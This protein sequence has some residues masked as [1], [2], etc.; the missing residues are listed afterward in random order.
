M[1]LIELW[2]QYNKVF[3]INK[4]NI[5]DTEGNIIERNQYI[6]I[7]TE[8]IDRD[9]KIEAAAAVSSVE[10]TTMNNNFKDEISV[11]NIGV[12]NLSS[13]LQLDG[14]MSQFKISVESC[15]LKQGSYLYDT[16]IETATITNQTFDDDLT[17]EEVLN[18]EEDIITSSTY[19]QEEKDI[20]T[21]YLSK[22]QKIDR[23]AAK[24]TLNVTTQRYNRVYNSKLSRNFEINDRILWYNCLN[25]HFFKD[26][27]ILKME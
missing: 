25:T 21:E 15:S 16:F 5:L 7:I 10:I 24:I 18:D 11:I 6:S 27:I 9:E 4:D 22:I 23:K 12:D 13:K 8:S 1:T 17:Q 26:T 20:S 14:A 19:M 2:N 3:A